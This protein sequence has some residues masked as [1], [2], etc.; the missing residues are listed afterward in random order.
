MI[1]RLAKHFS[2]FNSLVG[3][4]IFASLLLLPLFISI[5]GTLLINT[6]EHS[7][8]KAEQ[9]KLQ[10]Q[11]Y[12]LLSLTEFEDKKL[13]LP[14]TLTE[15]RFNQQNSGLYGAIYHANGNE[16]WRSTSADLFNTKLYDPEQIFSVG[17]RVFSEIST[18]NTI[19]N[20][21]SHDIE[22]YNED[23]SVTPLRFVIASDN[24]T[25]AAEVSA[26]QRRL[27]QWLG[28]LGISLVI[29][30]IMIMQWGLQPLKRLSTQLHAL[31]ENKIQQLDNDFPSEIRPVIDSFNTILTHEKSQR[32][33]YRNTMS[34][35]AHSLKTPLAVIQS[36]IS[37]SDNGDSTTIGDE[38]GRIN[39]IISHQLKRAV[40]RVNQNAIA[41]Q[42]DKV[43]IKAMVNRLIKILNK[44]Y[45]EKEITFNNQASDNDAFFGDEA[46]LL[47]IIGNLLDNACKYGKDQITIT[48][49]N[50]GQ[51]L[52]ILIS[53]NGNGIPEEQH[54]VLL[55]RGARG[56][57]A[58][59]GQ[60][61]GLSVAVDIVSSY[62]GGL[63]VTNNVDA[64]HLCGACFC[65]TLPQPA[66]QKNS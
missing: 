17:N 6:F 54:K 16:L 53:D 5:S 40:I 60:G 1:A 24:A 34:D 52:K 55:T 63:E 25:L 51:N 47:E 19:L 10:A 12:V 39:Q 11:L 27:W 15:P 65:V 44:V 36:H 46:D 32:E 4:F 48:T 20:W 50:D 9:E 22:W 62:G 18:D 3:R 30:Q 38:L 33:R 45:A 37:N 29:I 41:H 7:Q 23:D 64:P 58:Q 42:A 31:Q 61:I 2:I 59:A 43:P 49:E 8:K 26:Y 56:D 28:I 13:M 35:L 57:T 66:L 21:F 14:E